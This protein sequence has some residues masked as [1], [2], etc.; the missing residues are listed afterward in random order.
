MDFWAQHKDFVLKILLGFGVFLVALIARGITYGSDVDDARKQNKADAAKIRRKKIAI[1]SEISQLEAAARRLAA[2]AQA[3][4]KE[5][6]WNAA[7][8]TLELK[9]IQRTLGYMRRYR[10]EGKS[11][12]A[13][14]AD[15]RLRAIRDDTNGGF[16]QLRL[17]VRDSMLE[18][19]GEKNISLGTGIGYENLVQFDDPELLKY[20]LQLEL[21]ARVVRY[22]INARVDSLESVRITERAK[23]EVIPGANKEF[24]QEYAVQFSFTSG[25]RA[26]LDI[27]NQLEQ[28][29]PRV[30][31]RALQA[32]RAP[33]PADHI[34][35]ELT[36]MA[37]AANPDVPFVDEEK[38]EGQ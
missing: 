24:L 38:E 23:R 36:V 7:D 6:G 8:E 21:A 17:M 27:L 28:T 13:A 11:E 35:V 22:A 5:I 25:Q 2:N 16:G 29:L 3:I 31:V 4:T 1:P 18:E 15:R 34:A 14:E 19:A 12:L 26:A 32:E 10:G 20:L 9:L 37:V 33:R 30:P